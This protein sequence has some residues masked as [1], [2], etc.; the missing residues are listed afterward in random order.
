MG[1]AGT[2]TGSKRFKG[3]ISQVQSG[4][5]VWILIQIHHEHVFRRLGKTGDELGVRCYEGVRV[6]L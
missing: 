6:D 2:I 4:N 5:N 1:G 3:P